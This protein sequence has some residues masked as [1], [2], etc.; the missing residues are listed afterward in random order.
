MAVPDPAILPI[1]NL[2]ERHSPL[3][4]GDRKRISAAIVTSAR[5][6][7]LDPFLVTSI[8]LAESSGN[9]LAI[10]SGATVG[11]MQIHVPTWASLIDSE[12]IDLFRIEDNV[13]LGTRVLKGYTD[14]YGLWLGVMRYLGAGELS[15]KAME[16]VR[17][18]QGIYGK[19]SPI[20]WPEQN[21]GRVVIDAGHGGRDAGSTGPSGLKEKE[22][23]L[24]IA[25]R[26]RT[27]IESGLGAEVVLTRYD[28]VFVPLETR[29][30]I[31]NQVQ[32]DLFVSIHANSS[33]HRSI[34]GFET[35]FLSPTNSQEAMAVAARESGTSRESISAL[36]DR[37][38][39]ILL[40][41]KIAESREFATHIQ[42]ALATTIRTRRDRGV[43][44]APLAVLVGAEM[45]SIL[46]EVAFISNPEDERLLKGEG[47]RQ[48]IAE[49]LFEGVK[50]YSEILGGFKTA[51]T[52]D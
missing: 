15:E 34:R 32:A 47:Y 8:L 42:N 41:D 25:N 45:P 6:Y 48:Q 14:Q 22:L 26:L 24:D 39:D 43:K 36:R 3:R 33:S 27:N 44:P 50:S 40:R 31:A 4:S 28:D 2:L 51:R 20:P 52:R 38:R 37:I 49:A 16:D 1:E 30:A 17:L 11:I 18:V 19:G 10:S 9:P 29:T 7:E 5:K 21:L 23:V 12:G 46:A 13:D 35:F